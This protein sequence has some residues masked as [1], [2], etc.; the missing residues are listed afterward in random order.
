MNKNIQHRWPAGSAFA[1]ETAD[2]Q[3]ALC[4]NKKGL[5]IDEQS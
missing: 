4:N 2:T 3:I 1:S 5:L